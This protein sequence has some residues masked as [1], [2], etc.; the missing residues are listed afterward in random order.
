MGLNNPERQARWRTKR[1]EEIERLRNVVAEQSKQLAEARREIEIAALQQENAT[2]KI[3]L[4][5]ERKQHAATK[6]MAAKP[7][8]PPIDPDEVARLKETNRKLRLAL[9][10][11]KK[12]Y[13]G[14]SRRKGIM[15][16]ATYGKL[17]KCLHP[18][19]QPSD[20]ERSEACALLGQWKQDG[21]RA[22]RRAH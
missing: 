19:S 1:K 4:A 11:M 14:E 10:E 22:R 9:Q 15:T 7:A 5:D 21:D 12:W 18:D 17:M 13:E 3:A 2:L 16:F 6:A 8:P 20:A